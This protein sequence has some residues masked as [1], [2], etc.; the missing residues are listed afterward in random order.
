M[1]SLICLACVFIEVRFTLRNRWDRNYD[2][3]LGPGVLFL[4]KLNNVMRC[5][6]YVG[7]L[8]TSIFYNTNKVMIMYAITLIL[9]TV[10]LF[11]LIFKEKEM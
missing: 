10:A 11:L 7:T 9:N 2:F 5:A 6:T 1:I 8:V 4:V 3:W